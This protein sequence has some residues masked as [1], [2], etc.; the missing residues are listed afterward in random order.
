MLLMLLKKKV[1]SGP[2]VLLLG[3][4]V[5]LEGSPMVVLMRTAWRWTAMEGMVA[6]MT[7][8]AALKIQFSRAMFVPMMPV[9][10]CA[11]LICYS[12]MAFKRL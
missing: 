3:S 11:K 9:S 6:G 12:L 2:M 10:S 1:G 8:R 5:G 7:L 4:P